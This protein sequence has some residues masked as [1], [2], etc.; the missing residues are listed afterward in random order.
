MADRTGWG[1]NQVSKEGRRTSG[2]RKRPGRR[3]GGP[4]CRPWGGGEG[5]RM[6]GPRECE[7]QSSGETSLAEVLRMSWRQQR[8]RGR[9]VG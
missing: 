8:P 3:Q 5:L 1:F 7:L 2:R 4:P 6:S 9:P